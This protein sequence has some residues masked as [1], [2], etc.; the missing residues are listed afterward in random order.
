MMVLQGRLAPQALLVVTAMM[1]LQALQD[2]R[3]QRAIQAQLAQLAPLVPQAAP[4]QPAP[5]ALKAY[6]A[7]QVRWDHKARLGLPV[8]WGLW[9]HKVPLARRGRKVCKV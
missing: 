5:Q 1:A 6:L 7:R 8:Q 2:L 3:V 4:A 9:G